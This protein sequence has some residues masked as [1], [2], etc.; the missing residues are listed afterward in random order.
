MDCGTPFCHGSSTG[1]PLGNIIP[2]WNEAVY[3]GHWKEALDLLLATNVFPEFTGR[4]CPAPCEGACVL[5]LIRPAVNICKIELAIIEQGFRRWVTSRPSRAAMR[6]AERV[7]V[8]GSGPAGLATAQVLEPG[9]LQR[10]RLRE[11]RETG[12]TAALRHTRLQAGEM[13]GRPAHR[14]HGRARACSSS[15]A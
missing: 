10:D 7:A 15:A 1:C 9:G 12:R 8:V 4:I 3:N 2:E 11:G 14:P 13:G 6:R 5:G